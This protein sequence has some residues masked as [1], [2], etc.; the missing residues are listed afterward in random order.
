M[1]VPPPLIAFQIGLAGPPDGSSGSNGVWDLGH[2]VH[3]LK[4]MSK[5]ICWRIGADLD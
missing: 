3:D 2:L 4:K 5:L 1:A